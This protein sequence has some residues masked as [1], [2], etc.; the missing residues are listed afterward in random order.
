VVEALEERGAA[1][2]DFRAEVTTEL[3]TFILTGYTR[4]GLLVGFL[5]LVGEEAPLD[6]D[7]VPL[8]GIG[9]L[10]MT[11]A[12]KG[13]WGLKAVSKDSTATLSPRIVTG[14]GIPD[15]SFSHPHGRRD[16]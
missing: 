15:T 9:K 12:A 14:G 7:A 8:T 3:T 5:D 10:A 6:L 13:P 16:H 4:G 11:F 1:G 2:R